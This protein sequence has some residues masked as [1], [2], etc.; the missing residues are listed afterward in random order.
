MPQAL[1]DGQRDEVVID[2]VHG[3]T[4]PRDPPVRSSLGDRLQREESPEDRDEY[5]VGD[6]VPLAGEHLCLTRGPALSDRSCSFMGP[7]GTSLA[8]EGK[9]GGGHVCQSV[10]G[11]SPLL[12]NRISWDSVGS[13]A[14]MCVHCGPALS[15]AIAV[16][17]VPM[18]SRKAAVAL[19]AGLFRRAPPRARRTQSLGRRCKGAR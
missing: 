1:R 9:D 10:P 11:P 2:E 7:R 18:S 14:C 16:G 19:L 3:A 12:H 5:V 17:G 4:H 13:N 15:S 8:G 6:S